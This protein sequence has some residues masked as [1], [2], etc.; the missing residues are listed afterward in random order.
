MEEKKTINIGFRGWMLIIYQAIAF[1]TFTVFSNWPMN[2]LGD[3]YGGAQKI[4]TIY[5]AT[6][7][8]GIVVQLILS[9]CMRKIKNVK[10]MSVLFGAISLILALCIMLIPPAQLVLWQICYGLE[11]LFVILWC[12]FS[13]GILVGQWFP[14]RKGTIMGIATLAFPITNGLI[15]VFAGRVFKYG[16]PDVFGAFLPFFILGV[17]GLVIGIVF[18]K[19]YPEQC[20]GY[21]DNDKS[22]TPEI[23]KAM[24]EAEREAKKTSVW[25]L[26]N[27]LKNRDF[28]FAT[29]PIG[30]MLLCTVGFMTQTNAIFGVYAAELEPFGGFAGIMLM[31]CIVGCI[32]SYAVGLL[33]TKLGTK[34]ALLIAVVFMI[35]SGAI[36]MI[37]NVYC[38]II[39]VVFLALFQG[40]SSNFTVSAAA[41]YWR[42]EDF[43][44]VF[45]CVNPVANIIQAAGPMIIAM[46]LYNLGY[47]MVYAAILV[48]GIISLLL[49]LLFSPAHIKKVDDALRTNAGKELDDAL[50]GRK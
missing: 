6:T 34:K 12:T 2:I 36:G 48:L 7:L 9:G 11:V 10:I 42:R 29:L 19:D 31:V 47:Q 4:S 25:T 50:V 1:I 18:I 23:A 39:S 37:P 40:A 26:G 49:V 13:V 24:M 35:A 21:R 14:R 22:F 43:S 8:I 45:S 33:D 3:L 30:A 15:G 32:G 5:T 41:Q 16:A 28:W 20:G 38:L 27:T 46:L 44:S 17:I